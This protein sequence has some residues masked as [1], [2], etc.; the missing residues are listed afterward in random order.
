MKATD[1]LII[2]ICVALAISAL[3]GMLIGAWWQIFTLSACAILIAF[4]VAEIKKEDET[5]HKIKKQ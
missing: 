3:F 2:I 4:A 5:N 1:L